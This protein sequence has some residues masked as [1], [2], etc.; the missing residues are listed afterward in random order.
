MALASASALG[1]SLSEMAWE[2]A[3]L[4][5]KIGRIGGMDAV[6][7]VAW[8]VEVIK[9]L[10]QDA[11]AAG[12]SAL[13]S[14]IPID[15]T[16]AVSSLELSGFVTGDVGL[17]FE[18]Q[19]APHAS[20]PTSVDAPDDIAIR[21]VADGDLPALH[22]M[23]SGLFLHSY[24]YISPVFS[25]AE[26]N[27]L[28]RAWLTNSVLHGRADRVLVAARANTVVGFIT[29]RVGSDGIGVIELIGVGRPHASRGVGKR[30]VRAALRCF[31][32]LGA[33][34]VRVRTQATNL[35]AVGMYS[36]TG[37]RAAGVD[38]TLLKALPDHQEKSRS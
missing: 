23:A 18:Y 20:S 12:F 4:R 31:H 19:L 10:E 5:R 28:Y 35:A 30:L 15:R 36:A 29:C 6:A 21:P 32:D 17:T 38:M 26:A 8:G 27:R 24:Y 14:R 7:D 1:V 34:V 22:E 3:L 9:S 11:I 25:R 33:A 37:A 13:I 2:T 16:A